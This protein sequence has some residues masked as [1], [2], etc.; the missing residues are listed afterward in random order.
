VEAVL[1]FDVHPSAEL[2]DVE[3]G[4][5][6]VDPELFTYAPCLFGRE[7]RVCGNGAYS[8]VYVHG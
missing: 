4:R 3:T 7:V 2:L 1:E 8:V 5:V 6:P